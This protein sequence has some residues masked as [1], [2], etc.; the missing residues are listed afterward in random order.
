[1]AALLLLL[2]PLQLLSSRAGVAA[3]V[4]FRGGDDGGWVDD[5]PRTGSGGGHSLGAVLKHGERHLRV[6][7]P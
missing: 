7:Q 5:S 1:M 3:Q 6:Y 2:L 4:L